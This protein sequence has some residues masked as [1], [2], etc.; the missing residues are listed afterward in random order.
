MSTWS[1]EINQRNHAIL[2]IGDMMYLSLCILKVYRVKLTSS[3]A[4]NTSSLLP[5]FKMATKG[6]E[7]MM[8]QPQIYP[9]N[10][11]N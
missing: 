1:L 4:G 5:F 3:I 9:F 2:Q 8:S 11:V 7:I 10:E 6:E